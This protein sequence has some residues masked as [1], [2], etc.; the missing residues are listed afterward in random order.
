MYHEAHE[1]TDLFQCVVREGK[2]RFV[3][4]LVS[5]VIQYAYRKWEASRHLR[6]PARV[7]SKSPDSDLRCQNV[8]SVRL[9]S[10][11]IIRLTASECSAIP[12]AVPW[13]EAKHALGWFTWGQRGPLAGPDRCLLM[14]IRPLVTERR[15]CFIA[16]RRAGPR[17]AMDRYGNLRD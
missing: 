13:M 1:E 16:P 12:F 8:R 7:I 3:Q 2:K 17:Y 5:D 15:R 11:W 10:R 4:Y 9:S 6:R 14:E